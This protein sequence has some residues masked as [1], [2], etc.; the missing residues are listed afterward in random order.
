MTE[1]EV[2]YVIEY[3]TSM[4]LFIKFEVDCR[5]ILR[6]LYVKFLSRSYSLSE[7]LD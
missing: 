2:N 1:I 7:R 6:Q 4:L 3:N 5:L